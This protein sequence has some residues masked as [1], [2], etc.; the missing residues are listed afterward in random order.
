LPGTSVA[1]QSSVVWEDGILRADGGFLSA[2]LAYG[3]R[4]LEGLITT[5]EERLALVRET[6][7]IRR[8]S[9]AIPE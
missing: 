2:T 1:V 6:I 7:G 9:K 5:K 3:R 4:Q 8:L